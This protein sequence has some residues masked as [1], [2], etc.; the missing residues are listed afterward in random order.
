VTQNV[1]M[2]L[3]HK[4]YSFLARRTKSSFNKVV[5]KR[6]A[7]TRVLRV[8][9]S[10]SKLSTSMTG[11]PDTKIAVVVAKVTNDSRYTRVVPKMTV[12]ALGFTDTARARI[13]A[14]GGKCLTFD[15]LAV[16]RPT[17]A[18]TIL[19]RGKR[20]ARTA[21]KYFG[22]A[23]GTKGSTTRPRVLSVGRKFETAR[24]RRASRGYTN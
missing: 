6:L 8:P 10:V 20:S 5:A 9:V 22:R 14:A 16:A 3:L 21:N 15:Q 12:A 23:P 2:R 18:N 17:G 19:L 4:L 1:Y 7:S 13:E 11:K 24:G